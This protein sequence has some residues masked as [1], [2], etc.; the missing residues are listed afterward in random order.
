VSVL[1]A[2][3]VFLVDL[4]DGSVLGPSADA[5]F[6]PPP[7]PAAAPPLPR[8]LA[9]SGS[10]ST[11]VALVDA[12]PPLLVSHDAGRTWKAAGRGLP[13]GRAVAVSHENPD[14]VVFAAR[15][16]L[17]VSS[18]GGRFWRSLEAELPDVEGVAWA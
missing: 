9:A 1:T 6:D 14:D 10:G 4:E 3:G 5:E 7:Q 18:D 13:A 12:K 15:N 11:V 17:Y 2:D 8:L 16:R